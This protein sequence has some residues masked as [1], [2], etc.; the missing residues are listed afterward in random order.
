MMR[1]SSLKTMLL[2]KKRNDEL[3]MINQADISGTRGVF[4]P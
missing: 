4:Q 1:I 2:L 3:E